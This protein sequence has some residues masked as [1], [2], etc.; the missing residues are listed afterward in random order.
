MAFIRLLESF[1]FAVS[2]E[3]APVIDGPLLEYIFI[4]LAPEEH[5]LIGRTSRHQLSKG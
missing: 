5:N 1:A 3:G 4:K 2:I